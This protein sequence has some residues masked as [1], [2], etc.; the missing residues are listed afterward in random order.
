M[1]FKAVNFLFVDLSET[2]FC[3]AVVVV[4]VDKSEGV[5]I[6]LLGYRE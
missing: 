5:G 3:L 2:C 4:V 6:L 1:V